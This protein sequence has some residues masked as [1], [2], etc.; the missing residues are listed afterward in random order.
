M[1]PQFA[2]ATRSG[3]RTPWK[4]LKAVQRLRHSPSSAATGARMVSCALRSTG[5]RSTRRRLGGGLDDHPFSGHPTSP[6]ARHWEALRLLDLS[7]GE[8]P[9]P[10]TVAE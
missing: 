5:L 7:A 1:R 4:A 10:H 3:S 2:S 8:P 6:H 9:A